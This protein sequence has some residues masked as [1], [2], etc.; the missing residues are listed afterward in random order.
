MSNTIMGGEVFAIFAAAYYWFPKITGRMF[1]QKLGNLHFWWMFVSYNLTYI[2]MF[3]VGIHGLN[4][5]QFDYNPA[6]TTGNQIISS[7]TA[8]PKISRYQAWAK[9]SH[10]G[11]ITPT[12]EPSSGPKK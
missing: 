3:Q 2:A 1:N 9:R 7:T 10:S 8:A 11:R 5:R 12:A 4:R 6:F